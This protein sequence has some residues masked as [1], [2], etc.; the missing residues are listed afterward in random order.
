MGEGS[1]DAPPADPP[2]P[3]DSVVRLKMLLFVL[4]AVLEFSAMDNKA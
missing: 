4:K 1:S 2:P 3:V